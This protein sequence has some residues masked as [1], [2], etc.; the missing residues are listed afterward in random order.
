MSTHVVIGI[1]AATSSVMAYGQ[2]ITFSSKPLWQA[3]VN[4]DYNSINFTGFSDGTPINTQ[5]AES[6]L[7]VNGPA[8]IFGT[9]AFPNDGWGLHGPAGVH[10]TFDTPQNWIAV[11]YPGAV[12]FQLFMQGDL[13][14]TSM[15]FQPGGI[16]NFAGLVSDRTF[17]EVYLYKSTSPNVIVIDD[18]HWGGVPAPGAIGLL[19][20][21]SLF[22][23][24]RRG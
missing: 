4:G 13:L 10:L 11:D 9:S 16:G 15:F 22:S 8:F 6:G 7:A 23:R 18:L 3:A 5:Y 2:V 21:A 17:D 19:G 12:R 14:F 1:A 24:R 20:I